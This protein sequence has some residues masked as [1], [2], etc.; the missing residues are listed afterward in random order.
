[1]VWPLTNILLPIKDC[2]DMGD[3]LSET[4]MFAIEQSELLRT[5]NEELKAQLMGNSLINEL[6]RVLQSCTD[7]E[8]IIK[9]A[10][11]GIQDILGFSRVI[12]FEIDREEFCLRPRSWVGCD[13]LDPGKLA[14]PM[15]FDGGEITD[16]IFLNRHMIVDSPDAT[17]DL[18]ARTL[19]SFG[20]LVTPLVS[21]PTRKCWE[22]KSCDRMA[23]PAHGS[24]NPYCWSILGSAELL[25]AV[26]EENRRR[27]C[28]ACPCFRAEGVFWMDRSPGF[29][30]I[31]GDHIT[32]LST[33]ITHA[34]IIIEN[35]RIFNELERLNENLKSTNEQ[36]R[37]VNHDLSLAHAKINSDLEHARTI[38]QGLLPQNL[39]LKGFSLET[40][41]TPAEMVGGDYYDVFPVGDNRYG[42]IVADVSGHGIASALVM[43]MVKVLLKTIASNQSSPQKTLERVNEI[44]LSEVKTDNF[45][46][47]FYAV[48]DLDAHRL[49]YTSAGHCPVLLFDKVTN[50]CIQIK[51]DGL[52]L[53]VFPDMMLKEVPADFIPGTKRLLLYTDGLTEA[54]NHEGEMFDLC[55][56]E[57]VARET[58]GL[59][60][61][62]ATSRILQVQ[63]DFCGLDTKPEDDITL[64]V[65]DL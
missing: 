12:L 46:S 15:G 17:T 7:L 8:G 49:T 14:V 41:Y 37:V 45:V 55:R 3:K 51:A 52:F 64:V 19:G 2:F 4:R 57:E 26:S 48:L 9:T 23:C 27:G 53:G 47:I 31:T 61:R 54:Q 5:E 11:L 20:Y 18:F 50:E 44:F 13:E 35:F 62:K 59:D 30:P 63:R 28:M 29:D 24:F 43:T 39:I 10:L 65:L 38:Q 33:I 32:S 16:A 56:L 6:T 58:L 1:M 22:V 34:G 25:G 60:L 40:R 21:K 36:M 42:I